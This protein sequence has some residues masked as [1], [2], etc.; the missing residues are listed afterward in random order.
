[1]Q[2]TI[3][4]AEAIDGRRTEMEAAPKLGAGVTD[5]QA[6]EAV[7]VLHAHRSPSRKIEGPNGPVE[8][9]KIDDPALFN[10]A[11]KASFHSDS[12][13][14][15]GAFAEWSLT[16][17]EQ[18]SRSEKDAFWALGNASPSQRK[19]AFTDFEKSSSTTGGKPSPGGSP[20]RPTRPATSSSQRPSPSRAPH[21]QPH[22]RGGV[23]P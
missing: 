2:P 23:W 5:E 10:A 19:K 6:K 9:G 21:G 16:D 3:G 4:H 18:V 15:T 1:M 14:A 17:N 11:R 20:N 12:T 22:Q 13:E 7:G 8:V